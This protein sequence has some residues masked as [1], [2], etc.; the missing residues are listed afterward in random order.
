M[1]SA[2]YHLSLPSYPAG[3]IR[4]QF[5]WRHCFG[6]WCLLKVCQPQLCYPRDFLKSTPFASQYLYSTFKSKDFVSLCLSWVILSWDL[7][8]RLLLSFY[9]LCRSYSTHILQ[10]Q[11]FACAC[12]LGLSPHDYWLYQYRKLPGYRLCVPSY[13]HFLWG[14]CPD[15]QFHSKL[16]LKHL[17]FGF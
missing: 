7:C 16:S 4:S 10:S 17:L 15:P 3:R 1:T 11:F 8:S 5:G 9:L 2:H 14:I 12:C 13:F 6:N